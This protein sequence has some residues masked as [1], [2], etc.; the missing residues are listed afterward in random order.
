MIYHEQW[1]AQAERD[2]VVAR[3]LLAQPYYEWAAYCAQQAAEKAVKALRLALG[4]DGKDKDFK[5]HEMSKL[6]GTIPTLAPHDPSGLLKRVVVLDGHNQQARY[7]GMRGAGDQAPL[8]SYTKDDADDVI[9]IAD[10][11]VEYAKSLLPHAEALWRNAAPL[12]PPPVGPPPPAAGS[13]P[14]PVLQT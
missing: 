2:L 11:V 10:A 12:P 14:P 13:A 7:P 6:L 3:H 1:L 8:A 9:A 5:V 4:A